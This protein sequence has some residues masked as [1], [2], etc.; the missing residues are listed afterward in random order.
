MFSSRWTICHAKSDSQQQ[1]LKAMGK[2]FWQIGLI[3]RAFEDFRLLHYTLTQDNHKVHVFEKNN[4]M[5]LDS[6]GLA[7]LKILTL[8]HIDFH[9][10]KYNHTFLANGLSQPHPNDAKQFG[11]CQSITTWNPKLH[12]F[13]IRWRLHNGLLIAHHCITARDEFQMIIEFTGAKQEKFSV[14]KIYE[15]S[16]LTE[17]D[18]EYVRGKGLDP[19]QL[20]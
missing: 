7:A 3:D 8:G 1:L 12:L 13:T 20:L 16:A 14:K 2:S 19:N 15:R 18:L 17:S 6:N 5:F 11:E 4:R 10:I 9:E